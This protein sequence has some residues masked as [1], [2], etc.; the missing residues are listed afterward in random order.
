[1]IYRRALHSQRKADLSMR[2]FLMKVKGYC[3]CLT[4]CGEV[5]SNQEHVTTILNGL[6]ADYD[7][8]VTIITASKV[9]YSVQDVSMMLLDAEARQQITTV[10]TPSLA[11][12]V[13]HSPE[14]HGNDGGS[15]PAY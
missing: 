14:V 9:P 15:V 11:K 1:M 12:L 13:S 2:D 8:V 7:S 4:G 10:E 6:S 3:D 5:I